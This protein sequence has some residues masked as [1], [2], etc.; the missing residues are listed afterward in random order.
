MK[1]CA[2]ALMAVLVAGCTIQ[3]GSMG[4]SA[5][6]DASAA[7]AQ[8]GRQSG[9][10]GVEIT[11]SPD[12]KL[13]SIKATGSNVQGQETNAEAQA[14]ATAKAVSKQFSGTLSGLQIALMLGVGVVALYVFLEYGVPLLQKIFGRTLIR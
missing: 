4:A 6:A 5:G 10:A 11:L 3:I 2:I 7:M 9:A 14:E 12:G 1:R 13:L 8:A